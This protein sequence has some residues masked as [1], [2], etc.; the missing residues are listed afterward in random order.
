[1]DH[2]AIAEITGAAVPVAICA[3]R[4]MPAPCKDSISY[5]LAFATIVAVN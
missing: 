2:R 1:M 4:H 5:A 3:A